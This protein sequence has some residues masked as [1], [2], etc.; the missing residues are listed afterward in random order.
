[1]NRDYNVFG[2]TGKNSIFENRE[3]IGVRTQFFLFV[4]LYYVYIF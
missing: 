2:A 4:V 3:N 1:M